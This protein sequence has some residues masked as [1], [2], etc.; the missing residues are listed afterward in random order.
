MKFRKHN[1]TI[2][3]NTEKGLIIYY[4]SKIVM[5][6]QET[7]T[8]IYIGPFSVKRQ[9]N[10]TSYELSFPETYK[11]HP[12]FHTSSLKSARL[13]PFPGPESGPPAPAMFDGNEEYEVETIVDCRKRR[14]VIPFL[15]G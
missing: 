8:Y 14:N 3:K 7:G 9:I 6:I 10:P 4:Q 12:V 2:K 11:I 13:D 15:I 1:I 5:P